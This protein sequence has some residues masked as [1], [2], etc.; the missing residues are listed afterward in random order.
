M[1]TNESLKTK[2][3]AKEVQGVTRAGEN[4][5]KELLNSEEIKKGFQKALKERTPQ[6]ISTI[7]NL[8]SSD[9][10]LQNCHPMSIIKACTQAATLDLPIDKNLGYVWIN[11][12]K[13]KATFS[14]S[15][16][17]Y[18]QL[19]LRTGQYKSMN[20]MEVHEGE[21]VSWN[22]LTE[23]LVID[24]NKRESEAVI[25][26]AAYLKLLNGFKKTVYWRR[27]SL[28]KHQKKFSNRDF[29]GLN[30]YEDRALKTV[31]RNML[32]TWGVLSDEMQKAYLQDI[33]EG[34]SALEVP[35]VEVVGES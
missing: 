31:L 26:Y 6:Y 35:S 15:Y 22:P 13:D 12:Y 18:I 21:L 8:V 1:A 3:S 4:T 9:T 7:V 19:A 28:E 2:L 32:S 30:H 23:E 27:E 33:K 24:F 10:A 25:G 29:G 11:A 17:G 34:F 16:K 14:V 20:V 5:L